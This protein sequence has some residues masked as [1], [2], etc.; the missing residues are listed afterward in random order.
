M[1]L[2]QAALR[3]SVE[4]NT[5]RSKAPSADCGCRAQQ[6]R[7]NGMHE[8]ALLFGELCHVWTILL[9]R[10]A[11]AREYHV[12]CQL[13]QSCVERNWR[14]VTVELMC[15]AFESTLGQRSPLFCRSCTIR[16][17]LLTL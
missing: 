15:A 13:A 5:S 17:S 16:R 11:Q 14:M 9:R 3:G 12:L 1:G 7:R 4:G 10:C 6:P 8:V 2:I